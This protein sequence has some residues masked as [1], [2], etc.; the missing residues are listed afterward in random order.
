MT[1]YLSAQSS[2]QIIDTTSPLEKKVGKLFILG[3][4]GPD[5][6]P[7]IQQQLRRIQPGGIIWFRRNISTFEQIR[8]LNTKVQRLFPREP[9]LIMLDQEGGVVSR[10]HLR[11]PMPS[12]LAVGQTLSKDQ[13]E[14]YGTHVGALLRNLGF[15]TNLAPV[16][17]I[18]SPNEINFLGH[19]VFGSDIK[20]IEQAAFA[21]SQGLLKAGI[22]PVAKHFPGHGEVAQDTHKSLVRN[23]VSLE[24]LEKHDL[25]P[26]KDF[27]QQ[28]PNSAIMIA[29][30]AF[31]NIT[32]NETPASLSDQMINI[33]LRKHI[34][35][36][37][38]VMTDDLEMTG[39]ENN[40]TIGQRA[41][42]AILAGADMVMISWS[43]HQ[44]W[45]AYRA[46]LTAVRT[47]LISEQRLNRS[48]ERISQTQRR[49]QQQPSFHE[50]PNIS[51]H[52]IE[53]ISRELAWR[54]FFTARK[55]LILRV[56]QTP[57]QK[58]IVYSADNTFFHIFKS[59]FNEASDFDVTYQHI[60]K[61][62]NVGVIDQQ[63]RSEN[64]IG[65]FY[66]TGNGSARLLKQMS[67]RSKRRMIVVNS[68]YP[69]LIDSKNTYFS[70]IELLT[71][72]PRVA[73]WLADSLRNEPRRLKVTSY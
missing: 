53:K 32:Q 71:P 58:M 45:Q 8:E 4:P 19:R 15:N 26:F 50:L 47:G 35:F 3:F 21:F 61:T 11:D 52:E 67:S 64:T 44:Q 41:V 72:Y 1:I 59:R 24:Q 69:G 39:A 49:L 12:A 17:D 63:I 31:P 60:D 16:L 37:G 73:A 13:I 38:L 20:Q 14:N 40:E 65:I 6:K 9:P 23:M 7:M 18:S 54:R 25:P 48:L 33:E 10:I 34:G 5:F 46:V 29:H 30:I 57:V 22:L 51:A 42:R 66:V 43:Q 68:M 28:F 70:T 36:D 2:A 27:S 55:T 56:A 62:I